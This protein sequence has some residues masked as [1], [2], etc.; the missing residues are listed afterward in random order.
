MIDK[1]NLVFR[2]NVNN[3]LIHNSRQDVNTLCKALEKTTDKINELVYVVNE[4]EKEIKSLK[5][6]TTNK[7]E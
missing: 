1:L 5:P 6:T 2:T 4:L 3:G 7:G